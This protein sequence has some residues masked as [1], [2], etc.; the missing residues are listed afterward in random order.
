M[1]RVVYITCGGRTFIFDE[2]YEYRREVCRV[3][4]YCILVFSIFISRLKLWAHF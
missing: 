1:T 4:I 2:V 3:R